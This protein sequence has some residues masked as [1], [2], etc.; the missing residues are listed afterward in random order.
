MNTPYFKRP[1]IPLLSAMVPGVLIGLEYPFFK[2]TA[3]CC[4][5]ICL[6]RILLKIIRSKT[7]AASPP[8][9]FFLLGY[10]SI[11]PYTTHHQKPGHIAFLADTGS[12]EI[13]G[14]VHTTPRPA[15]HRVRFL[16]KVSH[17]IQN[18]VQQDVHGLVR[19]NVYGESNIT[20]GDRIRFKGKI[21]PLRNFSNPGSFDYR[22]YM[23]FQNVGGSTYVKNSNITF[24]KPVAGHVLTRRL[25]NVPEKIDKS[26][27]RLIETSCRNSEAQGLLK[28]LVTGNRREISPHTR[29][30]F[31]R[32]GTGHLLAISGL[33]IGIVGSA[34]FYILLRLLSFSQ[35]LLWSGNTRPAAAFLSIFPVTFYGMIAGMP[36]S[37]QRAVIVAA[38]ILAACCIKAE[39]DTM[40]TLAI[41]ALLIIISFPPTLFLFHSNSHLP[42]FFPSSTVF[43]KQATRLQHK[44]A[45]RLPYQAS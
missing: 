10:L 6:A 16:L 4:V 22:Q 41:A 19:V 24:I 32:T 1:V 35:P 3:Y 14:T 30:A 37:T 15:P 39:Q 43:P 36:P 42:L 5:L 18:T 8:A 40:N 21:S 45:A 20:R 38:L 23:T 9:L 44:K 31:N 26:I 2:K 17:I 11:L 28:A 7:A 12:L 34:A 33:H 27:S 13:S 29:E 25:A